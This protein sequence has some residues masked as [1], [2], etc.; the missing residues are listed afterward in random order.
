V[1]P[2][3]LQDKRDEYRTLDPDRGI[4]TYAYLFLGKASDLLEE[5]T[6]ST[7]HLKLHKKYIEMRPQTTTIAARM[8]CRHALS[9]L[10]YRGRLDLVDDSREVDLRA[11]APQDQ[12]PGTAV[13]VVE[14]LHR[15]EAFDTKSRHMTRNPNL[16]DSRRRKKSTPELCCLHPDR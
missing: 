1:P 4:A 6:E 3:G 14:P 2:Q 13:V 15:S 7:K 8:S 9:P 11:R 12:H 16:T 10:P 5:F